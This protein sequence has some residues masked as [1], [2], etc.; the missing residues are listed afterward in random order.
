MKLR[1]YVSNFRF[2]CISQT[3]LTSHHWQQVIFNRSMLAL[4]PLL[5]ATS[6]VIHSFWSK[7][8]LKAFFRKLWSLFLCL[9]LISFIKTLFNFPSKVRL[10]EVKTLSNQIHE[11]WMDL[12]FESFP[13]Q[14]ISIKVLTQISSSVWL[15]DQT[16]QT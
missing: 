1:A 5:T 2:F 15:T 7:T 6:S 3:S 12:I 16:N 8:D 4:L 13:V 11:M 10:L 9:N 14:L